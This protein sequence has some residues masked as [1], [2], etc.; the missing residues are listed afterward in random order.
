MDHEKDIVHS[1]AIKAGKRIYYLDVKFNKRGEMYL[2][3][4]ESKKIFMGEGPEAPFTFEKHKIFLYPEDFGKFIDGLSKAVGYIHQNQ[5]IEPRY[6]IAG[7][8][9]SIVPIE[10]PDDAPLDEELKIDIDFE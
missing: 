7:E 1:Q 6:D 8:A 5:P 4:T 3:I 10:T 2:A 9:A